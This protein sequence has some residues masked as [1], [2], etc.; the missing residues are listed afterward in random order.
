MNGLGVDKFD[1]AF[2]GKS[3]VVALVNSGEFFCHR[4]RSRADKCKKV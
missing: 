3:Q 1:T 2:I 4:E